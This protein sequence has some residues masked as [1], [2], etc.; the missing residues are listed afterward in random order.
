M[1]ARILESK[2]AQKGL[3]K[4]PSEIV[5]AYEIWARLVE[6][7]G[8]GILWEFK[9]Y[10]NEK[11][12]GVWEGHL[13]CRLNRKWRVIYSVDKQGHIEIVTVERVTPHDYRR[14]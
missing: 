3:A 13:S 9:G 5:R 1:K 12:S 14:N 6:D 10:H 8:S 11:L 4:A 2:R 7:H